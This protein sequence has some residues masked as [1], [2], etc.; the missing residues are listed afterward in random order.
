VEFIREGGVVPAQV[1]LP[2]QL[3]PGAALA[4]IEGAGY[5]LDAGG[6]SVLVNPGVNKWSAVWNA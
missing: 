6:E 4:R 5:T 3:A 2:R 1:K